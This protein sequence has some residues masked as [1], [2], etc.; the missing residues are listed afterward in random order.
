MKGI[1]STFFR[2][3]SV[4]KLIPSHELLSLK[5]LEKQKLVNTRECEGI[6][7]FHVADIFNYLNQTIDLKKHQCLLVLTNADLFPRD[8]WNF[9]FG[10]TKIISKIC[11]QSYARHHPSFDT[12]GE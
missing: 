10:M 9:V 5:K 4:K 6:K 11:I 8:G 2:G 3:I 1:I 7:Q 12:G